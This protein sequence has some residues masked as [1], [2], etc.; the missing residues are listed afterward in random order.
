LDRLLDEGGI[1]KWDRQV[2]VRLEVNGKL[3]CTMIPDFLVTDLRNR[4]TYVEIKGWPTPIWRLKR[5]LFE[6][7]FPKAAYVVIPAKEA[8]AL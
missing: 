6:A 2:K 3:V 4:Q 1:A 7:L 8:L 5:K